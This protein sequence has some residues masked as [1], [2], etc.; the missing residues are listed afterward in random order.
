MSKSKR[1]RH[2]GY[3][4]RFKANILSSSDSERGEDSK[5][6]K[7]MQAPFG[8]IVKIPKIVGNTDE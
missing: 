2:T 8:T 5:G 6:V 3:I 1:N 4:N 7:Y